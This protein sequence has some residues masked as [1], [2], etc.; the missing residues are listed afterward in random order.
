MTKYAVTPTNVERRFGE[1][2][3]IVSKTDTTG[4]LTYA[5]DVFLRIAD[6]TE[7]E[8]LGE[9]HSILRHPDM[10]RCIF[11]LLWERI[12][13]GKEIFAF[14]KNMTKGGD[15]YWVL[16][17]VTPS[18]DMG[19]R[20]LGYHSN[21]RVPDRSALAKIEPIYRELLAEEN[22]SADRKAGMQA[23]RQRLDSMLKA[24]GQEYDQFV[25]GLVA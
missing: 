24:A 8:V 16:A 12:S 9:P 22:R 7:A 20:I 1:D 13:A 14:V 3:I 15:F 10:P 4:R 23:G 17:H 19:G 25:F 5:N 6:F 18:F 2:E 21:R 11:N